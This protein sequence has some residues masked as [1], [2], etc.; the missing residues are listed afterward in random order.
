MTDYMWTIRTEKN[1][2]FF[3]IQ[4]LNSKVLGLQNWVN[5]VP[6]NRTGLVGKSDGFISDT[7]SLGCL[8]EIYVEKPKISYMNLELIQE[9]QN[10]DKN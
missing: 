5:M 10:R 4:R 2:K 8:W 7:L 1:S 6:F 9:F 3:Q